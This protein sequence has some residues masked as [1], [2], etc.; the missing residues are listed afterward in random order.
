MAAFVPYRR[1]QRV[2]IV[3]PAVN[4]NRSELPH[5]R[6]RAVGTH[7]YAGSQRAAVGELHMH[8]VSFAAQ[9]AGQIRLTLSTFCRRCHSAICTTRFSTMWPSASSPTSALSK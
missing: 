8:A 9:A 3:G 5:A 4:R 1:H 2:L 7:H 6:L